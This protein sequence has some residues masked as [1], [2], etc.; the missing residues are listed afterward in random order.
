[1]G[2]KVRCPSCGVWDKIGARLYPFRLAPSSIR[3]NSCD[4]TF[5]ANFEIRAD[6]TAVRLFWLCIYSTFFLSLSG[7]LGNAPVFAGMG[8]FILGSMIMAL[9]FGGFVGLI[10]SYF[11][12]VPVQLLIEG[13]IGA[14]SAVSATHKAVKRHAGN[15]L[16]DEEQRLAKYVGFD[17][18]NSMF[19]PPPQSDAPLDENPVSHTGRH[20]LIQAVQNTNEMSDEERRL[21]EFLANTEDTKFIH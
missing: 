10:S 11:F 17:T 7:A 4:K 16:S 21:M 5:D 9:I 3:C 12:A 13:T 15:L 18:E 14:S 8:S 6:I 20:Q 19:S 1:M 2:K